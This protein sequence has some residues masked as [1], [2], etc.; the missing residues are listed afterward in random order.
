MGVVD[1][2]GD[3]EEG[4]RRGGGSGASGGGDSEAWAGC[5][6]GSRGQGNMSRG[7]RLVALFPAQSAAHTCMHNH[8]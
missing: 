6:K 3:G 5:C 4:Q 1:A 7:R 8:S 2:D